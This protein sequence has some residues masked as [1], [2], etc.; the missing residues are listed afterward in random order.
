M[1][2]LSCIGSNR[3]SSSCRDD[4]IQYFGR[5]LWCSSHP[6]TINQASEWRQRRQ[7]EL[8]SHSF[9]IFNSN[10]RRFLPKLSTK[11]DLTAAHMQLFLWCSNNNSYPNIQS[12]ISLFISKRDGFRWQAKEI[13]SSNNCRDLNRQCCDLWPNRKVGNLLDYCNQGYNDLGSTDSFPLHALCEYNESFWGHHRHHQS[14]SRATCSIRY[15]R[16]PLDRVHPFAREMDPYPERPSR[17][18]QV[19]FGFY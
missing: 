14:T 8:Q 17:G 18:W 11:R 3:E 9:S 2:L 7:T 15:T 6:R 13:Q 12:T 10:G 1:H 16:N 19:E 5:P 4:M